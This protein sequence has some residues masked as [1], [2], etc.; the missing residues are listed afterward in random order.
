MES[1]ASRELQED[2]V[3]NFQEDEALPHYSNIF[4]GALN[5]GFPGH[6]TVKSHQSSKKQQFLRLTILFLESLLRGLTAA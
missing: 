4:H 6:W 5:D 3:K 1:F 2:S